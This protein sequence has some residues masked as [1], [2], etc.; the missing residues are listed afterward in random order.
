VAGAL[1]LAAP[2]ASALL[3]Q[4]PNGH[5]VSIAIR[6]G[7]VPTSVKGSIAAKNAARGAAARA[8][9]GLSQADNLNWQGGAVMHSQAPYL[10]FWIPS[11]DATLSATSQALIQRYFADSAADSG[12][13]QNVWGVDR[14][15]T[16]SSGFANYQQTFSASQAVVDT[17]AY[18]ANGCTVTSGG[19]PTCLTDA[20]ITAEIQRLI[21]ANHWPEDGNSSTVLPA[22]APE[23]FLVLPPDVN[24]CFDASTLNPQCS[25]NV[26]CAYHS[27]FTDSGT[28]NNVIYS[29][30]PTL[31]AAGAQAK[32]CQHDGN[33]A[34][35]EPN[36]DQVGDVAI[37][38][39]SHEFSESI[40][41]PIFACTVG[42]VPGNGCGWWNTANGQED[43]DQCNFFGSY[44][45]AHD[46]NPNAFT[47]TLGGSPTGS[48]GGT[49]F[50]QLVNGH[51]YYIQS[52][53]S[54]G[55]PGTG[56][57]TNCEL[58][59]APT[60]MSTSLTAPSTATPVGSLVTLTP[61]ASS[62]NGF[63]SVT[64][65][66][67]DGTTNFSNSGSAPTAVTHAY[68]RAG[69]YRA[70]ITTVDKVGNISTGTSNQFTVGSPPSASFSI[71]R[72]SAPN[73]A[74]VT[75]SSSSTDPDAGVTIASTAFSFGDGSAATSPSASHVYSKPGTYSVTMQVTNSL[76]LQSITTHTITIFRAQITGV[77]IKHK[78]R[79]GATVVVTVNAP[80]TL[81]GVPKS[82]KTV[83]SSGTFNLNLKLT[84]AQ[85]SKLAS[86]GHLT[87][88]LNVKF[89]PRA[90]AAFVKKV[91]IKF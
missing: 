76:G 70:A 27:D 65:A 63:S 86:T 4:L 49:L 73:G 6:S 72:S 16:D 15:Y 7:I 81:S 38:Y 39:I 29:L 47:P 90:G 80:G 9:S 1:A 51:Q 83:N 78:T 77:K 55:A 53:W 26:F 71:S 56:G 11:T 52:E 37:K 45:P 68:S 12:G 89:T 33:A 2:S 23:Y 31:L 19:F 21:G 61:A 22:N 59:P 60:T 85:Q 8:G 32:G 54:N 35:Q 67:G 25:S 48:P 57:D 18:P 66:F 17:Q 75:F 91:T 79:K 5:V 82:K 40:T 36:G 62:P 43:G 64:Y 30:I 34:V 20:Q 13:S 58:R 14:Q 84:S 88:T 46:S 69:F 50:N 28:S 10:I 44:N 24:E 42:G 87:V 3:V 74:T 41:D